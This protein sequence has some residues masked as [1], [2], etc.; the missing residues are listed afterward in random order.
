MLSGLLGG[1]FR[2]LVIHLEVAL[3]FDQSYKTLS[4]V[5]CRNICIISVKIVS[6]C[7][8]FLLIIFECKESCTLVKFFVNTP[9][10]NINDITNQRNFNCKH[11]CF[12]YLGQCNT[13]RNEPICVALPR[14]AKVSRICAS[15]SP[16]LQCCQQF[17]ITVSDKLHQCT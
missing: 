5:T 7:T 12:G 14:V 17:R 1:T 2:V 15:S 11:T 6:I 13:N 9:R 8:H 3:S 16:G 10:K 4:C